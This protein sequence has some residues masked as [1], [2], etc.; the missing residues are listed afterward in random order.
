MKLY[1]VVAFLPGQGEVVPINKRIYRS[2]SQAR[3]MRTRYLRGWWH[4]DPPAGHL[5]FVQEAEVEWAK[6]K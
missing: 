1:R 5:V 2:V 3:A 4:S 6:L